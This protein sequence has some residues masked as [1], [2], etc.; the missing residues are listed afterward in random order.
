MANQTNGQSEIGLTLS[1]Q[2]RAYAASGMSIM[3]S[4]NDVR[5]IARALELPEAIAAENV[6]ISNL[7]LLQA[8][9]ALSWF[10]TLWASLWLVPFVTDL[11]LLV[12]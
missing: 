1:D 2:L 6:T 4:P 12:Q 8:R 5:H 7:K 9:L 3:L 11:I 10:W